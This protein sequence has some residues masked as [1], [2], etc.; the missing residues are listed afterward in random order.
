[1]SSKTYIKLTEAIHLST[2]RYKIPGHISMHNHNYKWLV[3]AFQ[4][5]M[6][7]VI[8]ATSALL[9]YHCE[10]EGLN[11]KCKAFISGSK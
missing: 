3:L 7:M 2:P 11:I 5:G 10:F 1:M 4:L 6:N 8:I 9:L